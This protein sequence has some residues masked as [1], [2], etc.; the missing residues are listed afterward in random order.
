MMGRAGLDDFAADAFDTTRFA[1]LIRKSVRELVESILAK[2]PG[3]ADARQDIRAAGE[4][5]GNALVAHA[6]A[7]KR[8]STAHPLPARATNTGALPTGDDSNERARSF[9]AMAGVRL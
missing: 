7:A 2:V 3:E 9:R 4:R 8:P 1:S 5:L 6:E